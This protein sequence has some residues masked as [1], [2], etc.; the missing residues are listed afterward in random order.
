MV[1][2]NKSKNQ[3]LDTKIV[4]YI[5]NVGNRITEDKYNLIQETV[6]TFPKES[7]MLTNPTEGEFLASLV[8]LTKAK[9]CIEIGVFTGYSALC[10]AKALPEDG[11]LYA[12]DVSEEFTSLARKHWELN[13][14]DKKIELTLKD[15]LSVLKGLLEDPSNLN[16]FDLAYVDADKHNYI[17]YYELLL[18][19]LKP[20]GVIVFDNTL[21]SF[22]VCYDEDQSKET[23]GLRQ[24]N[25]LLHDDQRV[26][27]NM[28]NIADGVTVVIKN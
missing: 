9:R 25:K 5:Y 7:A 28:L 24:L 14:V 18:K 4:D 13:G 10:I 26:S 6:K 27:I 2:T 8:K 20:N 22:K 16:S 12:I 23:V 15:G 19:L 21:W 1:D 17:N 11:K 3:F